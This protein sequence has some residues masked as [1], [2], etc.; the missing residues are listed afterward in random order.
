MIHLTYSHRTESLFEQFATD[1]AAWRQGR[2]PQLEKA[3]D[4]VL[5]QLKQT[6]RKFVDHQAF[7]NYHET[8]GT[9]TGGGR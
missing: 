8:K 5:Q 9:A 2:D 7:P 1:L 6:P 3:V 4:L